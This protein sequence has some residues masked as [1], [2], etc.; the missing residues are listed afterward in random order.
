M[1]DIDEFKR[2]NDRYGHL[3]GDRVLQQVAQTVKAHLQRAGDQFFRLG[4][5]VC[6]DPQCQ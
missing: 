4:A 3:A 2:Y 1:L 6:P 5:R